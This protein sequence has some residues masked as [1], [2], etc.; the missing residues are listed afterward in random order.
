MVF[1]GDWEIDNMLMTDILE[2][3]SFYSGSTRRKMLTKQG[4]K[5]PQDGGSMLYGLTWRSY[6]APGKYRKKDPSTGKSMTKIMVERPE[7]NDIFSEFRDFYFPKFDYGSVQMNK[8]FPC[9][10]HIDSS[11]TTE[12]ILCCFGNY[13]GGLCVVEMEDKIIKYN[14]K[15]EPVQFDGSKY[16]H[17]VEPFEGTRYSLVFFHNKSS[18]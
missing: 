4:I 17:Y 13:T 9:P 15:V 12:S 7:L 1:S 2:D 14:P 6:L 5:H 3:V 10:R 18:N 8:N 16:Y 11:N